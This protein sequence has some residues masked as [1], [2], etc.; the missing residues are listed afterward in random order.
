VPT[1]TALELARL[2]PGR[3]VILGGPGVVSAG[4]ES[5]LAAYVAS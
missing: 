3:V 2:Q 5:A 4:V 1:A